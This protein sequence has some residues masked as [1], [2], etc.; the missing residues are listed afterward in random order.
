MGRARDPG[1]C[2]GRRDSLTLSI[3]EDRRSGRRVD[4]EWLG[5]R[6]CRPSFQDRQGMS[7]ARRDWVLVVEMVLRMSRLRKMV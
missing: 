2:A 5:D 6:L 3:S 1:W 4:R 7:V